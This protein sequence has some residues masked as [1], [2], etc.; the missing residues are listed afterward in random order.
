[1]SNTSTNASDRDEESV[2]LAREVGDPWLLS[3]AYFNLGKARKGLGDEARA[4][5]IFGESIRAFQRLK[6]P[7]DLAEVIEDIAVI[8]AG[9]QPAVGLPLP[10]GADRMV[11]DIPVV[12]AGRR[13]SP[14]CPPTSRRR[15]CRSAPP[16]RTP[17]SVGGSEPRRR[18]WRWRLRSA[19]CADAPGVANLR[20]FSARS[21]NR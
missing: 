2:R 10:G 17:R 20:A 8:A 12:Q 1:M 4:R 7:Y 19:R 9:E 18:R 6:D 13:A 15:A 11:V 16:P 21:A 5:E 14:S 3:L